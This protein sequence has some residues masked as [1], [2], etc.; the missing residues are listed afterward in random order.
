[1]AHK[2]GSDIDAWCTRCRLDTIHVVVSLKADGETAKRA[3]CKSCGGQH[4]YRPPKSGPNTK[5]KRKSTKTKRKT[6]KRKTSK[7]RRGTESRKTVDWSERVAAFQTAGAEPK[8]YTIR[9][10]FAADDFIDHV[11]FGLGVVIELAATNKISVM[12]EDGPRTL[13]MLHGRA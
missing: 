10:E 11:K 6:S 5:T 12:F 13:I 3:E 2:V 8:K 4:N 9:G 7:S 1:M